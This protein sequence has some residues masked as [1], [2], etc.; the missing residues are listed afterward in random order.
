ML[1]GGTEARSCRSGRPNIKESLG[2]KQKS[3]GHCNQCN[4]RQAE[5]SPST[6]HSRCLPGIIAEGKEHVGKFRRTSK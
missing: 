6:L 5:A 3:G 2:E 4:K 1:S